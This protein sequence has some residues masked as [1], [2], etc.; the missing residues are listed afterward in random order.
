M[1]IHF[2]KKDQNYLRKYDNAQADPAIQFFTEEELE[3]ED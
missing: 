3:G 1:A 2:F